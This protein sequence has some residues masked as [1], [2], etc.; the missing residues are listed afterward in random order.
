MDKKEIK[1]LNMR[2]IDINVNKYSQFDLLEKFEKSKKP[3]VSF[4]S[5]F[6]FDIKPE[7]DKI[8]CIANVEVKIIETN[9]LFAE[10]KV[11]NVFELKPMS[12]IIKPNDKNQFDIPN[13]I[14]HTVVSLSISTVRGILSEK[15]KGTFIQH[16]VYPL[17][18]PAILF[19]K[20]EK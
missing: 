1:T 14:L 15:L 12:E 5:S 18:N 2:F 3:L 13:D 10:L 8:S 6:K 11:E 4:E 7:E 17:I 9:E 19:E 16:E 20:N